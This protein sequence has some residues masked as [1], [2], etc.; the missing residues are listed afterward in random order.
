MTFVAKGWL[1]TVRRLGT[2]E[3]DSLDSIGREVRSSR[4]SGEQIQLVRLHP[5]VE[6]QGM[7]KDE[8]HRYCA[9]MTRAGIGSWPR[10]P[11]IGG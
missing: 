5:P 4:R 7:E 3:H 1:A 11:G 10:L 8:P 9:A 2:R 6:R